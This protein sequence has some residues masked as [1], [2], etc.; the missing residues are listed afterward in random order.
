MVFAYSGV[1][2]PH[3]EAVKTEKLNAKK[4]R[5]KITKNLSRLC[6]RSQVLGNVASS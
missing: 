1:R 5:K 6:N 3:H 2:K 4:F